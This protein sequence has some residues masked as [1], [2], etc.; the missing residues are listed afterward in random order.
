MARVSTHPN[1]EMKP[2]K[3]G[4]TTTDCDRGLHCFRKTK[5]L[6]KAGLAGRCRA[7]GS[8]LVDWSRLKARDLADARYTFSAL[9]REFIRH[10]FWHVAIDEAAVD[11]ARRKGLLGLWQYAQ[12]RIARHVAPASNAFDGRQTP[13]SG[14]VVYY[15]Q[16]ATAACCRKCV[17]EW[18]GIPQGRQMKPEEISYLV[19]LVIMYIKDRLPDLPEGNREDPT[20]PQ[21]ALQRQHRR[22][23]SRTTAAAHVR[24]SAGQ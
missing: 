3:I 21:E 16:H 14:N 10:H 23:R 24:D 2:L 6:V 20:S 8:D 22:A 15:A 1:N 11:R 19:D 13:W 12:S 7:C 4:C 9:K 18:H 17:E 5:K